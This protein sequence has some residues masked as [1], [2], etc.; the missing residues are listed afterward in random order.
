MLGNNWIALLVTLG[1]AI[2]WLRTNDWLAQR[3]VVSS[4][5]SR[6]IIHIGTGP[7]FV[8]CWLLFLDTSEARY[9]AV[10]VPLAI[11]AQFILVGTGIIHDPAAVKA[12]S[13][14]GDRREILRGPLLYGIAFVVLT[15]VF[16]K[17]SPLGIVA[18]M[19]MCGGDGLADVIGSK[20]GAEHLPWSEK[21]SWAGSIAVFMGGMLLTLLV[22]GVF[23]AAGTFHR[24]LMDF[25]PGIT[26]IAFGATLVES[27]PLADI[28]NLTVPTIAILLGFFLL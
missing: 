27:L 23:I 13:R 24:S 10:I 20:W 14:T 15:L 25:F 16:W 18:L 28:D 7:L 8:L 26:W 5:L 6:K 1:L 2:M 12:M 17:N 19:M 21:K 11:T 4:T 3:G 9:L 22:L